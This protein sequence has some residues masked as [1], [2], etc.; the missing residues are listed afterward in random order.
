MPDQG[1]SSTNIRDETK[2]LVKRR[3][4]QGKAKSISEYVDKAAKE[5]AETDE[6]DEIRDGLKIMKKV[7]KLLDKI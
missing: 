3:V 6:F 2:E 1:W 4:Q 7:E 5:S